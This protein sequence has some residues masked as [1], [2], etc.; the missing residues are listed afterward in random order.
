[1]ALAKFEMNL[2]TFILATQ[3]IHIMK[4]CTTYTTNLKIEFSVKVQLP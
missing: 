3:Y 4:S 2:T 1:M